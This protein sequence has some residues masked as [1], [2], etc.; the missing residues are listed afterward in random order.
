MKLPLNSLP[1]VLSLK[2]LPLFPL[3]NEP[4]VPGCPIPPDPIVIVY[5]VP[6]VTEDV[7][8]RTPPAPAPPAEPPPP[9]EILPE[10]RAVPAGRPDHHLRQPRSRPGFTV[11]PQG[12][13]AGKGCGSVNRACI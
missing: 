6:G 3:S 10:D 9:P 5:V 1:I 13:V 4:D 8:V 11:L 12:N 2:L 7:P